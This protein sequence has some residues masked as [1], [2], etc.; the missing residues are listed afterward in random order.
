MIIEIPHRPSD[1]QESH[2]Q[3]NF[4]SPFVPRDGVGDAFSYRNAASPIRSPVEM[5]DLQES[6]LHQWKKNFLHLSLGMVLEMRFPTEM[7]HLQ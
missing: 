3:W 7:P 5:R 1:L 2:L 6:H 4:F